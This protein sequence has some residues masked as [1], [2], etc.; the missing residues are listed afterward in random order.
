MMD[1][2][3]EMNG[4]MSDEDKKMYGSYEKKEMAEHDVQTLAEAGEIKM[5][6]DRLIMARHCAK[7][8]T[9]YLNEAAKG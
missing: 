9:K 5:D 4:K 3:Q 6:K 7:M 2:Y 1:Y 8:Q